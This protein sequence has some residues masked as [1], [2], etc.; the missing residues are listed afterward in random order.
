MWSRS[1]RES[2]EDSVLT[3]RR[4][5]RQGWQIVLLT[6]ESHRNGAEAEQINVSRKSWVYNQMTSV[7]GGSLEENDKAGLALLLLERFPPDETRGK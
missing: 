1:L 7:V 6:D 2:V 3:K 4:D 5:D